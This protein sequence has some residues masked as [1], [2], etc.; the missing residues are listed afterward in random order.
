MDAGRI[1]QV[2][3]PREVYQAPR[4]RWIAEFVGDINLIDGKL[5]IE[6]DDD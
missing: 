5:E 3:T 4:S 2:A 6:T 1:E